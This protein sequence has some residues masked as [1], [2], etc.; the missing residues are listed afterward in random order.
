MPTWARSQASSRPR[1]SQNDCRSESFCTISST[2]L[3]LLRQGAGEPQRYRKSQHRLP[4]QSVPLFLAPICRHI[5]PLR[6]VVLAGQIFWLVKKVSFPKAFGISQRLWQ[7]HTQKDKQEQ[8]EVII[9]LFMYIFIHIHGRIYVN[10]NVYIHMYVHIHLWR[11][12]LRKW[13]WGSRIMCAVP[14]IFQVTCVWEFVRWCSN[15]QIYIM[16]HRYMACMAVRISLHVGNIY[17][18]VYK[19][20]YQY[21]CIYIYT[22]AYIYL[23]YVN[24]YGYVCICIH[25][26][27]F[28]YVYI[29][30]CTHIMYIYVLLL[31]EKFEHS[32]G[33][34]R[35]TRLCLSF[36]CI[37][38][39]C[40]HM[41]THV[42]M[43]MYVYMN[44]DIYVYVY[45][46]IHI[47]INMHFRLVKLRMPNP[48]L[49]SIDV[50]VQ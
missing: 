34:H 24:I 8:K 46:Y 12:K 9:I 45:M 11:V 15:V 28:V 29:Y 32:R 19:H 36:L 25:I 3:L 21:I 4:Q 20:I 7:L 16:Y 13:N 44:I 43:Y 31:R 35:S 5:H 41:Q 30:I 18:C 26:H 50:Y 42:H 27:T 22:Y 38:H 2:L 1:Q 39:I 10:T 47:W 40:K 37:V 14:F 49:N 23:S 33:K 6:T 48:L 17:I